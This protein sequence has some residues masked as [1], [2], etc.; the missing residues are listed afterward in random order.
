MEPISYDEDLKEPSGTSKRAKS[1][2]RMIFN[3]D[4]SLDTLFQGY[5]RDS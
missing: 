5:E 4:G 3:E 2:I 1:S